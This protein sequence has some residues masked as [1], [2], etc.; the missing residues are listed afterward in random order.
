MGMALCGYTEP[1]NTERSVK[2]RQEKGVSKKLTIKIRSRD[3][4]RPQDPDGLK[5][6]RLRDVKRSVW[7]DK[8]CFR[9][10]LLLNANGGTWPDTI[11]LDTFPKRA[12]RPH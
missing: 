12:G 6:I 8:A 9:I 2:T 5:E 3:P 1:Q 10:L 4:K 11:N 7:E